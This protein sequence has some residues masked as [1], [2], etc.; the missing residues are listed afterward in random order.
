MLQS[1]FSFTNKEV[2]Q[3]L[4]RQ[5][6][7]CNSTHSKAHPAL[8]ARVHT[9]ERLNVCALIQ[10]RL[11]VHTLWLLKHSSRCHVTLYEEKR[12]FC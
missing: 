2:I 5:S 11:Q 9:Q 1:M 12:E 8:G 3:D 6:R 4:V 7:V 10:R